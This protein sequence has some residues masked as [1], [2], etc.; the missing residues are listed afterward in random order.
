MITYQVK[1]A[2]TL[3]PIPCVQN[4]GVTYYFDANGQAGHVYIPGNGHSD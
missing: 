1:L 4:A 2:S 3:L